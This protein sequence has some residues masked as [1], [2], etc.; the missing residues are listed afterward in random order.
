MARHIIVVG[1]V[2][3]VG[4]RF[5]SQQTAIKHKLAGWVRNNPDG[6]VEM[7]ISGAEE[8]MDHFLNEV[9][10][11]FNHAIQVDDVQV[12]HT[13]KEMHHHGFTIESYF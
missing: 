4:F 11:G 10:S 9:K 13:N 2:Q 3:G 8:N 12:K 7:E 6:T 5:K 1:H